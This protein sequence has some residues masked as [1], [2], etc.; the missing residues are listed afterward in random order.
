MKRIGILFFIF[1]MVILV[2][3]ISEVSAQDGGQPPPPGNQFNANR[4]PNLLEALGLSK[5]QV[6]QLRQLN[7]SLQPQ[8]RQ[9]EFNLREAKQSLD[10][11]VYG[12]ESSDAMIQERLQS[13]QTAQAEVAKIRTMMETSIRKVL[14]REQLFKF[15]QLRQQFAQRQ[16]NP[17]KMQNPINRPQPRR[18]GRPID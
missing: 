13:F 9:S 17:N 18:I 12:D 2:A 10:E 7:V 8:L 5:E 3:A 4:R 15:R 11:A 16:P 6:K 14:T 1:E